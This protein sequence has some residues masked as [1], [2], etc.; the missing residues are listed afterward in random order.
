MDEYNLKDIILQ[1]LPLFSS[2]GGSTKKIKAFF[3]P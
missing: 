3:S 2:K 1:Q